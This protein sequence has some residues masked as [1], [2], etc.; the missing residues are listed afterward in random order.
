MAKSLEALADEASYALVLGIGGGGDV[1][2][3]IPTARYLRWLGLR[4]L[5]GGLTW[6]RYVDRPGA[7]A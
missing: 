1:I 4:T 5:V 6:E 7:G 3:T 2:G